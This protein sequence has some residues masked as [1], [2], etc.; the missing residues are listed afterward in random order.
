V[1]VRESDLA[2]A[3][4]QGKESRRLC[5]GNIRK[6]DA[7]GLGFRHPHRSHLCAMTICQRLQQDKL[8][9]NQNMRR[10]SPPHYDDLV[11]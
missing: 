4:G 7:H 2:V 1:C 9:S 5:M 8:E 3:T 6:N 10:I 11:H